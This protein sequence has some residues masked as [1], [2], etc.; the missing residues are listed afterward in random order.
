MEKHNRGKS[1]A[2]RIPVSTKN[3]QPPSAPLPPPPFIFF[4]FGVIHEHF[5]PEAG[6]VCWQTEL[7]GKNHPEHPRLTHRLKQHLR[8]MDAEEG[9][10]HLCCTRV[11][12]QW[13]RKQFLSTLTSRSQSLE[14]QGDSQRH[15]FT[16]SK[17]GLTHHAAMCQALQV[18]L[19]W[20]P[21]SSPLQGGGETPSWICPLTAVLS[22][23][24]QLLQLK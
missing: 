4:F 7:R 20:A 15:G 14:A 9:E 17:R 24:K 6:N 10:P 12:W 23:Q 1:W 13:G 5:R 3:L 21:R 22:A 11:T 8:Q 16:P 18:C 19:P 2:K